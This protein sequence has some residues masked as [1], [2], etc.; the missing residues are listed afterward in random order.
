[1]SEYLDAHL[2]MWTSKVE[3]LFGVDIKS[4]WASNLHDRYIS[5]YIL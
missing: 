4:R 2:D 5:Q 3:P 1:M